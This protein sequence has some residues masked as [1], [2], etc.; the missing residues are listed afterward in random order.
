MR[1]KQF[2]FLYA[3][4]FGITQQSIYSKNNLSKLNE[5]RCNY[6]LVDS[7]LILL[8]DYDN[9]DRLLKISFNG[10][11]GN[12]GTMKILDN[13]N[14]VLIES[15]FELIK[16]PYYATVNISV[17]SVGSYQVILE[18][19]SQVHTATLVVQ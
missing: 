4:F 2:L 5:E 17:L 11:E 8:I 1:I 14:N 19:N 7:N 6:F 3:I 12:D 15:N 9:Q 13:N 10:N 18:T 16:S